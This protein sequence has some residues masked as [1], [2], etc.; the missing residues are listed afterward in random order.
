MVTH[1]SDSPR[2]LSTA[3]ERREAV[4]ASAIAA[5]AKDGFLGTPITAVAKHAGISPAYV[6]K[7]F[8]SKEG[9]FAAALDRCF[10]LTLVAFAEGAANSTEQTPEGVLSAMGATYA[11]LI[12]N[13]DL[14]ALQ[15]HAQ[16]AANVPEIGAS[17]RR[18]LQKLVEFVK[19]RSGAPDAAVQQFMAYGL[20]CHFISMLALHTEPAPWAGILTAGIRHP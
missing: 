2:I 16:S 11:D 18:G 13:R 8:P 17:Y 19:T 20:L 5:F 1:M 14:L 15:V 9:L 6:F 10:E 4:I 7:L 3:D 12:A